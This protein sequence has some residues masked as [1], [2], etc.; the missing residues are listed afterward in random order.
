[1]KIFSLIFTIIAMSIAA[2]P[3]SHGEDPILFV[4][5]FRPGEEGAIHSYRF[6]GE[7][8]K[9]TLLNRTTDVE[10]PFFMALSA[11]GKYL[12]SIHAP[13]FGGKEDKE[14][15]AY[16]IEGRSGKL[17]LINRQSSRGIASCY[18]DI[19]S[20]GKTVAVANYSSGDV[21]S[22][23]VQDN[24]GLSE[25]VSYFKHEGEVTNA[26]SIEFSPDDRFA[27]AADLG[28]DKILS[29][30]VDANTSEMT[31]NDPPFIELPKGSGP[32]HVRFH[33]NGKFLY[34]I[35]EKGN[36]VS[37]FSY[38]QGKG[39]LS[40]LQIISTIPDD[41]EG[42]TFTADLKITPDGHFLY[43]TNRG[44]DS[45]AC[46]SISEEGK[47][48]LISIIPSQG[49][50]PQNLAIT[51]NGKH[52]ICANMP[53]DNLVVFNIDSKSGSL[54]ATG[55]LTDIPKPACIMILP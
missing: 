44:H 10:N 15:A 26:H 25:S 13:S 41:F 38:D 1:M 12:Y 8:G 16:K 18:L 2:T 43:G 31:P 54:T 14:V 49:K 37:A 17:S 11:N 22:F 52:L 6:D 9:L 3:S 33:P 4:S 27:F 7:T 39:A 51:P 28:I 50:G 35:N 53:G 46:F 40:D 29:Y 20:K 45:I 48:I 19:D 34:A 30:R 23:P 21:A 42:K 32:R 55:E 47:L 5:A 36:T 24:G